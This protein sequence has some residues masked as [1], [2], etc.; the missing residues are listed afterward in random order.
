MK[1]LAIIASL[2]PAVASAEG[3]IDIINAGYGIITGVLIPLAFAL[4]LFYFL[5]GVAKYIKAEG[6][7]KATKEGRS[8]MIWG[9]VGLFVASSIWGIVAFIRTEFGL[10]DIKQAERELTP[11]V[12]SKV[13]PSP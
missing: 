11:Y 12:K 8:I 3:V 9:I 2:V 13:E 1:K 5:W 4:C 6:D 7:E 10:A